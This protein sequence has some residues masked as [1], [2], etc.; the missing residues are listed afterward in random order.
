MKKRL[1]SI[2]LSLCMVASCVSFGS[3]TTTAKSV[4]TQSVSAMAGSSV[5]LG[6]QDPQKDVQGSAILHCFNWSYNAIKSNL[7][8]IK[9]AG[10]TA[11]QTS[12]GQVPKD[13]NAN[14]KDVEGQW[15]KLYQPIDIAIADSGQSWLGSKAELKALC[16]EADKYGIKVIVDVV[17]NHTADVDSSGNV[18]SNISPQNKPPFNGTQYYHMNG[19][20][21]D[22]D[23]NR[24][25]VVQGSIGQPDLNTGDSYIQQ[26]FANLLKE[27]A[28]LGVD[29]FRFDA[30]KHIELP[31]D[32]GCGSQFWP[33]I[34]NAAKSVN[35]NLFFYG[36][37]LNYA[38]TS[39][40]NYGTYMSYT[41]NYC[42]DKLLASANS[43]N[44]SGLADSAYYKGGSADKT[45]LWVESHDTY[46]GGSGSAG[47]K[48]TKSVSNATVTKAWAIA[49]A[50][51]NS[52]SLF[53]ARPAVNMGSAST[54]TTWKSTAV[55]EVNKFKNVFAGQSE[56]VSSSGDVAYVERGTEGVVISKLGGSGSVT[57]SARKMKNGTY[58]DQVSGSTF[59][60][61]G[62]QIKG[63]VGSSGVAV[64]YN[65]APAG[66]SASVNPGSKTYNTDT[67]TLT[68]NYDNATSGQYSIDGGAYTSFTNGKQI[69]IGRGV[70]YGTKTTVSVKASDGKTTSDVTSYTYT[71]VDPSLVQKVYFDNSSYNWSTVY[72]YIYADESTNN[73]TWPGAQMTKTSSNLYELEIPSQFANGK[74]IFTESY[75]ATTNRYPMDGE[76]GLDMAGKTMIMKAN[77]VWEE[78]NPTP[79]QPTQPTTV[80]PTV[81]PTQ[82][83]QPTQPTVPVDKILVGDVD[84]NGV[85]TVADTTDT[86]MMIVGSK[87]MSDKARIAA[88]VDGNGVVNIKDAT[89]IQYYLVGKI[90]SANHCGTYVGGETPSQPTTQPT[91]QPSKD[92]IYFQNESNWNT[93]NIYFWSEADTQMT[94]WPGKPMESIGNGVYRFELPESAQYVIFNNGSQQ[95]RDITLEG[96]NKIFKNNGWV[97]YNG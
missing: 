42:S 5:G 17:A 68:L 27:Y 9:K 63:N 28:T 69:T 58:K 40:N 95:T 23:N 96:M 48:N 12:P 32:S 78:Y 34:L 19:L 88:D 53:F 72:A 49:A 29:G 77:H 57:L 86:Q 83:T 85:I 60:V 44:A 89:Y 13:F 75:S 82:P 59:T 66:P 16:Q 54:D 45:I 3:L 46:M 14:Y 55:A 33:T 76:P 22:D 39:I 61:S 11:V 73:G 47:I 81:A 4:D 35:S 64:V 62:G 21:A 51:A 90:D 84:M 67:L 20:N 30:A 70:A 74:V 80:K 52:S 15:W 8:D 87:S 97:D 37:V 92:Y 25:K 2:A 79:T 7:A 91:T 43:N 94:S 26:R 1:T 50:R 41:D 56:S 10:Y 24:Y 65:T 71:K 38:G 36:E 31:S 18:P 93:V 6:S